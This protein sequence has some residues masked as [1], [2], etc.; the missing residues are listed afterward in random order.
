MGRVGAILIVGVFLSFPLTPLAFIFAC[1]V[2]WGVEWLIHEDKKKIHEQKKA[3]RK[4]IH[5]EN[6]AK[7]ADS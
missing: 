3:D 1:F 4:A 7:G 2:A 6:D 5:E